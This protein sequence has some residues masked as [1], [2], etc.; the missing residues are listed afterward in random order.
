EG[1]RLLLGGEASH[2]AT[3]IHPCFDDLEGDLAS[4]GFG[5][6]GEPYFAHTTGTDTAQQPKRPDSHPWF[7]RRLAV[8]QLVG[9]LHHSPATGGPGGA[10]PGPCVNRAS[11]A[12]VGC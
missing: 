3:G 7:R 9:Q 11:L 2:D 5:L 6:L 8:G 1:E 12:L 10:S 4:N